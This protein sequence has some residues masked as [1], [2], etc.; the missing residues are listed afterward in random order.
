MNVKD[1]LSEH[2]ERKRASTVELAI[3]L[4]MVF[5]H[6]TYYPELWANVE[7]HNAWV[8]TYDYI[9]PVIDEIIRRGK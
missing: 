9:K 8:R 7:A 5:D 4:K 1:E 3:C 6:F 2:G